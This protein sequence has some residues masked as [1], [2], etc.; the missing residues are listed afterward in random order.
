MGVDLIA[1]LK[2]KYIV[3]V[4]KGNMIMGY[5]DVIE[6]LKALA[7]QNRFDN[8]ILHGEAMTIGEIVDN[9]I[10]LIELQGRCIDE[11]INYSD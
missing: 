9:A 3:V 10:K 8:A 5:D 2:W 4:K 6:W 1:Q 7:V 11:S